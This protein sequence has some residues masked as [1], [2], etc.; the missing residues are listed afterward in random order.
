MAIDIRA[1]ADDGE[2]ARWYDVCEVPFGEHATAAG[3]A[4][5]RALLPLDRALAAYDGPAMVGTAASYPFQVTVPGGA[6]LPAAGVSNV[7]VLATHRRRGVLRQLMH[8][9]LDDAAARGEVL[10]VLNASE[11]AI[12]GRFG[13]GSAQRVHSYRIDTHRAGFRSDAMALVAERPPLRYVPQ[14]EAAAVVAPIHAAYA[15]GRPGEVARSDA[16]WAAVLGAD[17]VWKGG[18]D[19]WVVVADPRPAHDD[20]G[21][22][23]LFTTG[24]DRRH[25][26][27]RLEVRELVAARPATEAALWRLVLDVDLVDTV[28]AHAVPTDCLLRHWLV[29]PR[30]VQVT[31][32][33]DYLWVRLL[34]VAAALAARRYPSP[35]TIV[36]DVVDRFRPADAG[37]Y[38]LEVDDTG[39]ASCARLPSG[40]GPADLRL[41]MEDLA[42][43]FLG[44]GRVDHLVAAGRGTELVPGAAALATALF[45]WPVA[46]MC[47]TRF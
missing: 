19:L 40:D 15:A 2:L 43:L 45:T 22:Y 27:L 20:P 42:A 16:W 38:Q 17:K 35:G 18:G 5:E 12:Y 21:G 9:Q 41:D 46:P 47:L 1:V 25:G 37:R 13:Y 3:L 28:H 6:T 31:R 33:G 34:D 44:A 39:A 10:A 23:V 14:A 7:G 11:S 8:H 32:D 30:Q 29:D 24:E 4:V 36:L 26:R